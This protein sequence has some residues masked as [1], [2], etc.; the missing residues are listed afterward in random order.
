MQ[1]QL[2]LMI[3]VFFRNDVVVRRSLLKLRLMQLRLLQLSLVLR[4][5]TN[6]IAPL[7]ESNSGSSNLVSWSLKP[8]AGEV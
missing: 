6:C 8:I 5:S 2:N 4:Q 3:R 1:L 7:V